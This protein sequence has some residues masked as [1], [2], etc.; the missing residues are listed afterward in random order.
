M[1]SETIPCIIGPID[2]HSA[3]RGSLAT[4]LALSMVFSLKS[5]IIVSVVTT[6]VEL[7]TPAMYLKIVQL[8]RSVA[9]PMLRQQANIA[10]SPRSV[11]R[12]RPIR[13]ERYPQNRPVVPPNA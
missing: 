10:H 6:T 4:F 8:A 13:S 5:P 7:A 2:P 12:R 11:T 1:L 3:I 9:N